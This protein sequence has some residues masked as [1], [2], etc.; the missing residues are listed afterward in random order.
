M[1]LAH[2]FLQYGNKEDKLYRG[3]Q[4]KSIIITFLTR[5]SVKIICKPYFCN[6]LFKKSHKIDIEWFWL[7]R[8]QNNCSRILQEVKELSMLLK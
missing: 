7:I 5:R 8:F 1:L 4:M 2:F 3:Y 6:L